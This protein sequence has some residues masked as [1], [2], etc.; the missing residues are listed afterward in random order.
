MSVVEGAEAAE[1]FA[2]G[3]YPLLSAATPEA[4]RDLILK[5]G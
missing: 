3:L 2:S 5:H 1:R 4:E